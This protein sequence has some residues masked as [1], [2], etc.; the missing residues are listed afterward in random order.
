MT[1]RC[2]S[3]RPAPA[4]R[5]SEP[6]G[7]STG[8]TPKRP[9]GGLSAG[10]SRILSQA[11]LSNTLLPSRSIAALSF[12]RGAWQGGVVLH[13]EERW[14]ESER[15]YKA[16]AALWDELARE[17]P[18]IAPY[19]SKLADVHGSLAHLYRGQGGKQ[20][21]A[22]AEFRLA[23]EVADRLTREA[24]DEIAYQESLARIL[25]GYGNLRVNQGDRGGSEAA[26]QRA[27]AIIE[28][29]ARDRPDVTKHQLGL[30][31]YLASLGQTFYTQYKFPQAEEAL[32]RAVTILEKLAADHPQD[33]KISADLG[34]RYGLIAEVLTLRGDRQ[35]ALEWAG[36]AITVYRSL[37]R[38]PSNL[39]IGQ[40]GLS[41]ALAGRAELLMRLGRHAEAITDFEEIIV[42]TSGNRH[43]ELFRAFH[44]LTKARLERSV[45]PGSRGSRDARHTFTGGMA[46]RRVYH[47]F[48]MNCYDTACLFAALA[49]LS[50]Q[51]QG[52]TVEERQRLYQR[53][54][55]R[56]LDLLDR[57]RAPGE[58]GK[59]IPLDE[60]RKEP[61]LD[62]LRANPRFQRPDDGSGV[63]PDNPFQGPRGNDHASSSS[64]LAERTAGS[65]PAGGRSLRI[66]L[67]TGRRS[68]PHRGLPGSR[69]R[70][71]AH[72]AAPGTPA[73]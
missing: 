31:R 68:T 6:F 9:K 20:D 42:L 25:N 35:S 18:N 51:D 72:A 66:R 24:P 50:L 53:D 17:H 56:A 12:A 1:R 10:G 46:G 30:A 49:K 65:R 13:D 38:D 57:M 52:R 41:G 54:L 7:I 34:E 64:R 60:I 16:A 61:L 5:W 21:E 43:S 28:K 63:P 48:W 45:G 15:E 19:R 14:G 59:S 58:Y 40:R 73:S 39:Q 2:G 47:F 29:L 4:C 55:E 70:A 22:E 8:T 26:Q 32:K 71:T 44:A 69:G 3:R 36:R 67:E 11:I 62:P 23:L 27:V 37:A 33:M